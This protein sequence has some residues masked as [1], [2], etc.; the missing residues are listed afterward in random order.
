MTSTSPAPAG[1]GILERMPQTPVISLKNIEKFYQ[2][3]LQR[4]YVLR[5]HLA[6]LRARRVRLD[7]GAVGRRQVDAAAHHRHARQRRGP[8][9]LLLPASRCTGSAPKDRARAAQ[10]AHRLRVPE[11]SPARSPHG[12]REP[13]HPALVPRHQEVRSAT[14]WSATSST[15][16]AIVGK[17]DLYPNQLSGGQQQLVAVA[18]AR[19]LQPDGHPRGRADRQ[20]ALEPGHARSWS[21]SRS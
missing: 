21:C 6:R 20:P 11:L 8:A 4:T 13:R 16:F 15:R 2:H 12:L 17:K 10:A 19:H 1:Y 3:G 18:R 14:A 5:R 7:H 9:M